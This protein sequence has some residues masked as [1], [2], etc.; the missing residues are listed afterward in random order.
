LNCL[1][2]YFWE[3]ELGRSGRARGYEIV[4]CHATTRLALGH[5]GGIA[6]ALVAAG[7]VLGAGE[8]LAGAG[9]VWILPA[10]CAVS[11]AL[12]LLLHGWRRSIEPTVLRAAADLALL[13]PL[14]FLPLLL[15]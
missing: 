14:L 11:A 15:R 10:A 4:G 5:L 7:V 13:T 9:M 2:I 3:H 8:C 12:L 1:F 6:A